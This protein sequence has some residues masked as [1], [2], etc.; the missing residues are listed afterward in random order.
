MAPLA[1]YFSK[2]ELM[3]QLQSHQCVGFHKKEDF[4]GDLEVPDDV[5]DFLFLGETNRP[6]SGPAGLAPIMPFQWQVIWVVSGPPRSKR[7]KG[8]PPGLVGPTSR[9][10]TGSSGPRQAL[11]DLQN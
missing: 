5:L 4:I 8:S 9:D 3:A 7:L 6:K 11:A 10:Q 2:S 1:T